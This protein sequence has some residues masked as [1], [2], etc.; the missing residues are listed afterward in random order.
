L[1][2]PYRPVA[3]T[4]EIGGEAGDQRVR[5]LANTVN[6]GRQIGLGVEGQAASLSI[7]SRVYI[8]LLDVGKLQASTSEEAG[9]IMRDMHFA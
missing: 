3:G 9:V 6:Q 7:Y 4:M 5:V 1:D 8:E 2:D